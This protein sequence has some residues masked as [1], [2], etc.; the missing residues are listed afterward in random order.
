MSLS[1][2]AATTTTVLQS[3]HQQHIEQVKGRGRRASNPLA[4]SLKITGRYSDDDD[5]VPLDEWR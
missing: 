1:E 5:W 3:S 2:P 4:L